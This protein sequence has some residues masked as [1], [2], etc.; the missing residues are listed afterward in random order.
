MSLS[1]EEALKVIEKA[2]QKAETLGVKISISVVDSSGIP[3]AFVR[4]DGA[5]IATPEIAAGKAYTAVAF[6]RTTK[7]FAERFKDQPQVLTSIMST[8]P[9]RIL[10]LPGGGYRYYEV[11]RSWGPSV[12][13]GPPRTKIM[14]ALPPGRSNHGSLYACK[15]RIL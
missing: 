4:M 2:K 5:G 12:S 6:R 10:G 14:S 11:V 7:E 3:V 8:K 15:V 13:V 9:G 1:S